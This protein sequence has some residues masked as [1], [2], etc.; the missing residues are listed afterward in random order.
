MDKT[1]QFYLI[2]FITLIIL[3]IFSFILSRKSYKIA[4]REK[5]FMEIIDHDKR[6]RKRIIYQTNFLKI[7]LWMRPFIL[8]EKRIFR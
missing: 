2:I 8:G 7:V 1:E 6:L 5:I 4:K 3:T